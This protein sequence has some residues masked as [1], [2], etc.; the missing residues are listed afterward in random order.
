M[1][2]GIIAI[3]L[4]V[5][6]SN[7]IVHRAGA[8]RVYGAIGDVPENRAGLL[9][10]TSPYDPS[11]SPSRFFGERI[12]AA[13]ELYHSG[14]ID[15]VI[16]SGDN[17]HRTYNEPQ[18]MRTALQESGVPQEAIVLDFA[19][20]RTLDSVVRAKAVF[21][22][23]EFTIISQEFHTRR[24]LFLAQSNGIDAVAFVAGGG[25]NS[26]SV[27]AREALARCLAVID[28]LVLGTQPRFLGDP[29]PVPVEISLDS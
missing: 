11:G 13:A 14:R 17:E 9:L 8:D 7:L 15:F 28:V 2:H 19:G 5:G 6:I 10:G 27:L 22:Q 24:A 26:L 18:Y 1:T 29:E 20:F 4:L 21:Q 16:A 25:D 12:D 3:L 23:E